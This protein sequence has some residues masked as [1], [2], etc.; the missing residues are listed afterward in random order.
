VCPPQLRPQSSL[1]LQLKSA[2]LL[3]ALFS[4]YYLAFF[5]AASTWVSV[6]WAVALG[7]VVAAIGMQM[8]HDGN[9]GAY[10]KCAPVEAKIASPLCQPTGLP[11]VGPALPALGR[12]DLHLLRAA[13]P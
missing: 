2:G 8:A 11:T 6:A 13:W 5:T 4:T 9:H 3:A 12:S 10:T 7:T 1:L